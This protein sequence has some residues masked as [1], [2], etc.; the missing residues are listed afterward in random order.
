MKTELIRTISLYDTIILHDMC[1]LIR[2][3]T[4][5]SAA[6]QKSC[7]KHILKKIFL[8]WARLN[9]PSLS[10]IPLMRWTM[11][12]MKAHLSLSAIRQIRKES[13]ISVILP[14]PN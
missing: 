14:A 12:H 9:R 7:V 3:P 13:T 10:Y 5:H 2:M 1:V 8:R 6:L 4:D 11:K